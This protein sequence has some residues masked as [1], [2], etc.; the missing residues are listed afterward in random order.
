MKNCPTL[1]IIAIEQT[2]F[3]PYGKQRFFFED[4]VNAA[5][6]LELNFFFFSPFEIYKNEIEGWVFEN[7]NWERQKQERPDF[8]YDRAFSALETERKELADYRQFLKDESLKVL[9]PVDMALLCDD[10][11]AF[12]HF[13][14]ERKL[15]TLE[16][17]HFKAIESEKLF[18]SQ[19]CYFIKPMS[20]SGGLGIYVVK[21]TKAGL[22]LNN[23]LNDESRHFESLPLL[24]AFLSEKIKSE[25][26]FI[27]P[28]AKIFDFENAPIDLRVLIQNQG[29][30]TYQISGMALRQGQAGSNV[31]NL[32]SGGTALAF[33]EIAEWLEEVLHFSTSSILEQVKKISFDTCRAIDQK[34]GEFAEIG[35]DFLLSTEGPVIMEGNARPSRWVFNVLADRYQDEAKKSLVYKSQRALSVKMPAV[36]AKNF[37]ELEKLT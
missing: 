12:H 36:F 31:S 4:M 28:K 8:I 6:D 30:S 5:A 25:Q 10:K 9:N 19:Q 27:Q 35:L 7:G 24:I 3:P 13:L 18:E 34:F 17:L 16:V 33:E 22:V 29:G 23:H 32:Q 14:Q 15:P 1:G 11:A 26:Y 20:G 21:K 2:D 37:A